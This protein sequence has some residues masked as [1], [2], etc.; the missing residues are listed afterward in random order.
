MAEKTT[1]TERIPVRIT[2]T[3]PVLGTM[4]ARDVAVQ[5]LRILAGEEV[6]QPDEEESLPPDENKGITA[7]HK[8]NG[9]P[10]L[11]D[12]QVKGFLKEAGKVF[13]GIQGVKNLKSKV[14]QALFIVPRQIPIQ[15]PTSYNWNSLEQE[16]TR[17]VIGERPGDIPLLVRPVRAD[18]PMGPRSAI[19]A[20][21]IIPAGS[22]IDITVEIFT[23]ILNVDVV[24][25][26]MT[27]G[28]YQGIGQWRNGSYGRFEFEKR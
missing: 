9:K 13:N 11:Y 24:M 20:S 14:T 18:T 15:M 4:P 25:E 26:L 27:Y 10:I 28:K 3:E 23:S 6:M 22:Y 19:L 1:V 16:D 12:Y 7:F 21:E 2:F 17:I 8:V 5:Y